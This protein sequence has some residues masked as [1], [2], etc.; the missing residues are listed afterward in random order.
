VEH[1]LYIPVLII[2]AGLALSHL[3]PMYVGDGLRRQSRFFALIAVFVH[4]SVLVVNATVHSGVPGFPEALSTAA[5]GVMAAYAFVS[6]EKTNVLGLFLT[7]I[8]TV[9]LGISLV[10]PRHRIEAAVDVTTSPWLPI[11]LG[12]VFAGLGGFALAFAVGCAYLFVR[13]RLKQKRIGGLFRFPSLELLDRIQF[14]ATLSGFVFL[15]LGIAAGGAWAAASLEL[16]RTWT[17]DPKVLFTILIWVWYAVALQLRLVRGWRG[18]W[19]ALFSIVGFIA[20]VFSLVLF[21][22]VSSGWH[23]YG[24]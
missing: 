22:F 13:H 20:V 7:P 12:L 5:L 6:G 19:A 9:L 18:R 24:T 10:A 16:E 17:W 3:L 15:T 4:M 21:N 14:R 8:A 23:T 1:L 11:H 2:Y